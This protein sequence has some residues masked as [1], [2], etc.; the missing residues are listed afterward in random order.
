[1]REFEE[2]EKY[3]SGALRLL[4]DCYALKN[5]VSFTAEQ[6]EAMRKGDF[7]RFLRLAG[8]YD[9]LRAYLSAFIS[10]DMKTVKAVLYSNFEEDLM[11][12][13]ADLW[14]LDRPD[15][16]EYLAF[17]VMT[18]GYKFAINRLLFQQ[19]IT[20]SVNVLRNTTKIEYVPHIFDLFLK[21][22]DYVE[23][24]KKSLQQQPSK[25]SKFCDC[26]VVKNAEIAQQ[27]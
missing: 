14:G 2:L 10:E 15:A 19:L 3:S 6:Y 1:M 9:V 23:V 11:L 12:R 25:H 4:Q 13:L 5:G 17:Y 24:K 27:I 7:P 21:L 16:N 8:P 22:I 20:F 18:S 26:S